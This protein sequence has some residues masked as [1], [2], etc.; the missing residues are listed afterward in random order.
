MILTKE[1]ILTLT[2]LKEVGIKGV[3]PQKIFAIGA[4]IDNRNIEIKSYEDLAKLMSDMCVDAFGM[5][6]GRRGLPSF[7]FH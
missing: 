6:W 1:K 4:E 5:S 2:C 3:G 7:K